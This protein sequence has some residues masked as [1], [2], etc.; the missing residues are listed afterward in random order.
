MTMK[1]SRRAGKFPRPRVR[2]FARGIVT[3]QNGTTA[4][5]RFHPM[6]RFTVKSLAFDGRGRSP[7]DR[8]DIARALSDAYLVS[9]G[10]A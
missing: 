9:L 6:A 7:R 1:T 8:L 10:W 4:R 2:I 3:Y 5:S